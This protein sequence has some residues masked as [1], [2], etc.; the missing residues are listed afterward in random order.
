MTT[1]FRCRRISPRGRVD[2]DACPLSMDT[3][4]PRGISRSDHTR[5]TTSPPDPISLPVA[6]GYSGP[7]PDPARRCG[8]LPILRLSRRRRRDPE[9]E[10]VTAGGDESVCKPDPVPACAGGD[11]PSGCTVAG[12]LERPTRRLGRAALER[13]RSRTPGSAAFDLAPG[14]VY[15]A[16]PVTRGAGA[17]LPHRFTLTGARAP[18]VCFLWHCPAGHPG[19][20]LTTALLCGVRT[21]LGGRRRHSRA[22][23]CRRGRPTDSSGPLCR[24]PGAPGPR[25]PV[26]R[27]YRGYLRGPRRRDGRRCLRPRPA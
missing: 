22:R 6:V 26:R 13:L 17:L 3:R 16:A 20:P 25:P 19:L 21:F 27:R 5:D 24:P 11:H 23:S 14:G 18:A 10:G 8:P 7:L 9:L 12:H 1:G 2:V 4:G 15:R